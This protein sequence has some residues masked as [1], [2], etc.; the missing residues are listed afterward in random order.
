MS[1]NLASYIL[2]DWSAPKSVGALV[3]TR[4]GGV[5]KKPYDSFN[6]ALHVDDAIAAVTENRER[7]QQRLGTIC[8]PQWLEQVHGIAVVEA[9]AGGPVLRGDAVITEKAGLPCAVLTADCLPVFFCDLSGS[10]VAVAHAGWRGLAHG[11]LEAT[12][13]KFNAPPDEIMAWLGPAIGPEYFEVGPEVQESFV[14]HMPQ[15]AQAFV[16]NKEHAGYYFADLYQLARLRLQAQGVTQ[17]T[18]GGYCTYS[19]AA[20]FYSYRRENCTGRMAS[21]IWRLDI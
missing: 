15:A 3:T 12:L 6:L 14:S 13:A 21:L 16:P 11:V 19:D 1:I 2:P 7:L 17:I 10:Q 20:R 5:S 4:V 9:V 8:K 18:G